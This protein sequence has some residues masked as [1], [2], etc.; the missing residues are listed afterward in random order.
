MTKT[1][2]IRM[3]LSLAALLCLP[4]CGA[5]GERPAPVTAPPASSAPAEAATATPTPAPA[6]KIVIV[7]ARGM[8]ETESTARLLEAFN[9]QSET[10]TVKYQELA[11]DSSQRYNQLVASFAAQNA[12]IDVFDA[13]AVWPAEFAARG[14]AA[15]VDDYVSREQVN[16][17][18]YWAGMISALSYDGQ[19]WGMPKTASAGVLYYR[20]DLVPEP[21]GTWEEL[22]AAA[23]AVPAG[24][25]GFVANGAANDT[26]VGIAL[27]MIY[28]YGGQVLSSDGRVVI[29]SDNAVA[30]L[31]RMR[32]LYDADISP[33]NILGMT[34]NDACVYFL[35][36]RSA[37]MRNW[38]YAWAIG[39]HADN[40]VKG[41]YA[42]APLP[43][44]D[45]GNGA[46]L[47]GV[48]LMMNKQTK[49]PDAVWEFMR[50]VSGEEGQTLLAVEGGRIPALRWVMQADEV[51]AANPHFGDD[52]FVRAV[53]SAAPRAVTPY[54]SAISAVMQQE[55][56]T[57]L[58]N[59]Q[60]ARAAAAAME[61]RITEVLSEQ[62]YGLE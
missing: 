37:M 58:R 43:A 45:A 34:D 38:P 31:E 26:L 6:P 42:I 22:A 30:G 21:P 20:T 40:A 9:A 16:L 47:G 33:E 61:R 3:T 17:T 35:Q 7:Y 2:K 48:V 23:G 52:N 36:G 53:E 44:G 8:D 50:Y 28:A 27:E 32:T 19:L 59:E 29:N 41:L 54:Y 15:S 62:M 55:L 1:A 18:K 11:S 51:V 56:A 46:V 14:Y 4:G 49:N 24:M 60:S 12:E 57:F 5:F 39:K 10:V 13:D 25:H